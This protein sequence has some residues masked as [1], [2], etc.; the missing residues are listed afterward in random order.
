[1]RLSGL[2]VAPVVGAA[3]VDPVMA[4]AHARANIIILIIA[5]S[6]S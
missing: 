6:F 1:M 3:K 4:V 2:S 5:A